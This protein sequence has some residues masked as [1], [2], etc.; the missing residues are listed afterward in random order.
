LLGDTIGD[1]LDR[2]VAVHAD[3]EAMVDVTAGRRWTYREFNSS[4]DSLA[5]GLAA[6]GLVKGDRVI[7][8]EVGLTVPRRG[9]IPRYVRVVDEFPMTVTGKVRK[10]E[11]RE[12]SVELLGLA[13][14]AA[15]RHA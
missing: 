12:R 11:M 10:V 13:G 14:A 7:D 6:H 2:T 4:V 5:L 8:P 9:L 15:A 1:N 3:R